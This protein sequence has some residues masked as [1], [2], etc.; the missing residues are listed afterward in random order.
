MLDTHVLLW[1]ANEP[2]R[3]SKRAQALVEAEDT[4]L[5]FSVASLWEIAIKRGLG[6]GNL[7]ADPRRLRQRSLETGFSEIV[8]DA[9]HAFAAGTLPPV[10]GDP[11]DRILVAQAMTE[12]ATLMTADRVLRGYEIDVVLA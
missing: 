9:E 5:C 11:F 1:V 12:G 6:R 3:L 7:S 8:I 10:H 4:R 2:E